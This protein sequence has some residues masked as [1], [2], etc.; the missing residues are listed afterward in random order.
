MVLPLVVGVDGSESGL[1]A[2]DWAADEAARHGLPLRIVH[3]SLWERY[4]AAVLAD[5]AEAAP[6]VVTEHDI[7]EGIVAQA[8]A[9][10]RQRVETLEIGTDVVPQDPASALLREAGGAAAVVTGVRGKG[11]IKE[12]LLGSVSLSLAARAPCPVVVVRGSPRNRD[13]VNG[14]VVL[15]VGGPATGPAAA[16]FAFREAAVR[17]GTLEAVRVWRRPAHRTAPHPLLRGAPDHRREEDAAT[18]LEEAL[19]AVGEFPAGEAGPVVHRTV[20]EGSVRQT[21][22]DRSAAADLLVVGAP[23]RHPHLGP[24]LGHV[25]HTLLHHAD[26]PVA[27]VPHHGEPVS[28]EP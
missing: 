14:R 21:L 8:A 18:L 4:E 26:C 16:R 7:A 24:Q 1:R 23:R 17:R 22:L 15:G 5:A 2:V 6:D 27:V 19:A 10:A 12:L 13:G 20:V 25:G 28:G 9:R 11:P 3:A